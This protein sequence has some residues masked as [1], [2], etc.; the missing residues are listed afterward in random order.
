M[1]KTADP[2]L[3]ALEELPEWVS[4]RGMHCGGARGALPW[5]ASL[6]LGFHSPSGHKVE[7]S[8]GLPKYTL[9]TR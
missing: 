6:P 3:T 4:L 9:V 1:K 5:A 7:S 2:Q 8:F